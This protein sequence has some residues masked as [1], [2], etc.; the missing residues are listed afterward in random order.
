MKHNVRFYRLSVQ[1]FFSINFN[2]KTVLQ[3]YR[4]LFVSPV[5]VI[6][7]KTFLFYSFPFFFFLIL[8]LNA[9]YAIISNRYFFASDVFVL[10]RLLRKMNNTRNP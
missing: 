10:V 3:S 1:S 8:R 6:S 4:R 5:I 9:L 7:F 2:V